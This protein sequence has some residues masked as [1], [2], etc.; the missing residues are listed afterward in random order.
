MKTGR[1]IDHDI[2]KLHALDARR[3][4]HRLSHG[5]QGVKLLLDSHG[6]KG[7]PHLVRRRR[8]RRRYAGA[9]GREVRL[10]PRG[11]DGATG[12]PATAVEAETGAKVLARLDAAAALEVVARTNAGAATEAGEAAAGRAK[13]V[14][15]AAGTGTTSRFRVFSRFRAVVTATTHQ[16]YS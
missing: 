7:A 14:D 1:R 4:R 8:R 3:Y 6:V 15:V 13:D 10:L 5:V 9:S 12:V 2:N 16:G 11:I